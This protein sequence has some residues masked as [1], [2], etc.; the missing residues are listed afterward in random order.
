M[1]GLYSSDII[2]CNMEGY[3]SSTWD[4]C[5]LCEMRSPYT[6]I[7]KGMGGLSLIAYNHHG[8]IT[9]GNFYIYGGSVLQVG[10]ITAGGSF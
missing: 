2:P 6:S 4:K 7:M 10:S 3:G 9:H 1:G 5:I 8:I